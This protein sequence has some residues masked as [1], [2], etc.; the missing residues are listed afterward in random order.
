MDFYLCAQ[1][2]RQFLLNDG[3]FW[4]FSDLQNVLFPSLWRESG[5]RWKKTHE[6][7]F[8]WHELAS[9]LDYECL[10][11]TASQVKRQEDKAGELHSL[12]EASSRK[13]N[14]LNCGSPASRFLCHQNDQSCKSTSVKP[15]AG[16]STKYQAHARVHAFFWGFVISDIA[17]LY[18]QPS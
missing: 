17:G 8:P 5:V 14:R 15:K 3:L 4:M 10:Y 1:Y 12:R 16:F 18:H 2:R 6:G 7:H 13:G 11:F 9:L